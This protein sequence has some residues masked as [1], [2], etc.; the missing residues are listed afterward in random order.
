MDRVFDS[1]LMRQ[2]SDALD[3][4]AAS[5]IV[6]LVPLG[7]P[8]PTHYVACFHCR[9]LVKS[10][11]GDVE[12]AGYFEAGICFPPDY[13]RRAD[14]FKV[15]TWFGP[16]DVWHPNISDRGPVICIGRLAPGTSLK[17]IVHQV[18]EVITYQKYT[19]NEF[20]SLNKAACAW[21]R[22]HAHRFPIDRR[23]LRR[24]TLNLEVS[25]T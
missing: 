16:P 1:F 14:P 13:L 11:A 12:E 7:G 6:G 18:Y 8:P 10:P 21:A 15:V 17:D 23:P 5:D 9:G 2:H 3:L 4:S 25:P 19:P 22:S 24:R 20:D